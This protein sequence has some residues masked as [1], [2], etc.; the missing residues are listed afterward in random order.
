MKR[1]EAGFSRERQAR[2]FRLHGASAEGIGANL[3]PKGYKK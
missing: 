1:H 2:F 3:S